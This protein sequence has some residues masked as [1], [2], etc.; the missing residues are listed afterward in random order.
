MNKLRFSSKQEAMQ[1]LADV[2][3]KKIKIASDYKIYHKSYANAATEARNLAEKR[4]FEI[5][6]DSWFDKVATGKGKPKEEG[7]TISHIIELFKNG[8]KQKKCLAFQVY[9]MG[10][11]NYELNAYIN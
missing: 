9:N 2:T 6:E 10:N 11:G 7:D 3:G 5:D 1:Y 8:K 4:G